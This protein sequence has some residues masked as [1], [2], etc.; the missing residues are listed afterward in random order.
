[1]TYLVV[2]LWE[3]LMRR[4]TCLD[5][6]AGQKLTTTDILSA[7]SFSRLQREGVEQTNLS[8]ELGELRRHL[9]VKRVGQMSLRILS[10]LLKLVKTV[11]KL[12]TKIL[13]L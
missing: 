3:V 10:L 2:C 13:I 12:M 4:N 8:F 6:S 7:L 9:Y 11:G 1:V 5:L